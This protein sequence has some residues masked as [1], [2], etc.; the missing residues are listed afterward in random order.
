MRSALAQAS[1]AL[2]K[3]LPAGEREEWLAF[4]K[5]VDALLDRATRG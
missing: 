1:P 5:E 3:T 4:W 2:L